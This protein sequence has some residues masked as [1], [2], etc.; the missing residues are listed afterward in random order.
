MVFQYLRESHQVNGTAFAYVNLQKAIALSFEEANRGQEV[1]DIEDEIEDLE[2]ARFQAELEQALAA[3]RAESSN[4]ADS[5]RSTSGSRQEFTDTQSDNQ[6]ES[7]TQLLIE[8]SGTVLSEFLLER[9]Q[10]ERERLAR[11]KRLRPSTSTAT[12]NEDDEKDEELRGPPT[13]RQQI[14][15]SCGVR[16]GNDCTSSSSQRGVE[17]PQQ[18]SANV[19]T[20]DQLFWNGELRQTA[21]QHGE[22]RKDEKPTFRLTEVLGK[23]SELAFAILSSYALDLS[24]IYGFFDLS[25]PVILVAQPDPS[26]QAS[27]KYIF[28]NWIRT[29]PFLRDGRGCMHMKLFYKTGRLRVVV[30]TA[31]LIAYDYRDMENT[32]W[33]QDFPQRNEPIR[34]DSK[35]SQDF[36]AV[37]QGVLRSLHVQPALKTIVND[38]VRNPGLLAQS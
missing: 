32:I 25:V 18:V 35:V 11:Q 14:S 26:G 22:P 20:I 30:S 27:L 24:W 37:L 5:A 3:S 4:R 28:P 7:S 10:M 23:K 9:A 2:E 38:N 19:S 33:L 29:T 21:T 8:A 13:K 34:C 1:I 16:V 31:N 15:R 36:P 6:S 12:N 17:A